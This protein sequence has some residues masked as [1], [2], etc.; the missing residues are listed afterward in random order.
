MGLP[1]HVVHQDRKEVMVRL[2]PKVTEVL[3]V[4]L[5]CLV[6]QDP[7]DLRARRVTRVSPE[8]LVR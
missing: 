7:W 2:D 1:D 6:P 5:V 8:S 3:R 4:S